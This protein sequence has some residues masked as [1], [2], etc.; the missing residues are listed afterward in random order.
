MKRTPI[1]FFC[2]NRPKETKAALEQISNFRDGRDLFIFCDGPRNIEEKKK[3]KEVE[4]IAKQYNPTFLATTMLN[5][6][7]KNSVISGVNH[8][9]SLGYEQV[10]VIEDDI[11]IG[12]N[13]LNFCDQALE[14]Y[15][16]QQ[17]IF[18]V[19]GF[20]FPGISK[21]GGI[22]T[23]RRFCSWGW[24]IWKD[25][26]E[27]INFDAAQPFDNFLKDKKSLAEVSEN[28]HE[29]LKFVR[30]GKIDSWATFAMFECVKKKLKNI[31]PC[32]P[33]VKN[34]GFVG[35]THFKKSDPI[36]KIYN[37]V[38]FD[39]EAL[40]PAIIIEEGL[41]KKFHKLGAS[42]KRLKGKNLKKLSLLTIGFV[43]GFLAG[44]LWR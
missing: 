43:V 32:Q 23:H 31:Y 34:I 41:E 2:F 13:F 38:D 12:R 7:L 17:Q 15:R 10:A 33:L 42:G 16:D 4:L 22:F 39:P 35:G 27:K 24:A 37:K 5:K 25:R 8:V 40:I 28:F 6:G 29:F 1:I 9:F 44:F 11:I 19:T 26:W 20:N 14:E 3:V 36:S 21:C 30:N 18:S